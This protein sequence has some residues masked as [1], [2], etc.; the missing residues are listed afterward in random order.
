MSLQFL[1]DGYNI[2]HSIEFET[3]IAARK[4]PSMQQR[5]CDER[6]EELSCQM[7][8]VMQAELEEQRNHLI[9]LIEHDHPQGSLNNSVTIVFDGKAGV[10]SRAA[11]SKI[12]V[13]FS[14]NESAD[15]KIK[16]L[17]STVAS[18]KNIVVVTDDRTLQYAV[19]ALGAQ[20]KSVKAF[21]GKKRMSLIQEKRK[22]KMKEFKEKAKHISKTMEF[23]ITSEMEK[24]W[25][26]KKDNNSSC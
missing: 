15:E 12:K 25:L 1:L 5:R 9:T 8:E 2:V 20:V 24:I 18:P 7:S 6:N 4:L 21:L 14:E 26:K 23:E 22:N 10:W 17:V 3:S 16:Y 11:S 19:K 13:H